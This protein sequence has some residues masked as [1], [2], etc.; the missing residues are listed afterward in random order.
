[1]IKMNNIKGA[2]IKMNNIKDNNFTKKHLVVQLL[3][4]KFRHRF[5]NGKPSELTVNNSPFYWTV[6]PTGTR[7]FIYIDQ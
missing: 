5:T 7:V 1:M 4:K 3:V 2:M 6:K